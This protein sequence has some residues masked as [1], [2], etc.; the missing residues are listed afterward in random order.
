M[1][2]DK[3]KL[4]LFAITM[5]NIIAVDS[6]RTLPISAQYGFSLIFYYLIAGLFFF[7]PS[8][9]VSA[10]LGTGW[11][12]RGGIYIWIKEAFG[13]KTASIIIWIN[14]VYN[15]AWYPTIMALIAGVFAYTF[16][17]SLVDNPYYIISVILVLFW[18]ATFLNC[19]GM[20][21]S[22][23]IS[24]MGAIIGTLLPMLFIIVLAFVYL[25]QQRP[26]AIEISSH[27]FFPSGSTYDKLGFF[28]SILFGLLGLE[29]AATHAGEMVDPKRDYPKSLFI[30]VIAILSSIIL[31]S[32][33]IAIV[34][35]SGTLNLVVG[36]V[37]A[38]SAF[39]Q[40]F[41]MPYM[42][43][44]IAIAIVIGGLSGVSAWI[45]GPTKG[46]MVASRDEMLPKFFNKENEHG[47][48]I[49]T[50]LTQAVIV[51]LLSLFYLFMPSVNST[52]I[53]L[54]IVTA[55]LAMIV[56]I[57]LFAASII[58]HHKKRD[59]K[60]TFKIPG[61]NIG[62]W[63][64]AGSGITISVLALI[65]GFIPPKALLISNVASYELLLVGVMI[66]LSLLPLILSKL[67]TK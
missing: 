3:R 27:T 38:F 64:V 8:A 10:E 61:G 26:L 34:V 31:S 41:N 56:Y 51:T 35:P 52:F 5:I 43:K 65:A 15:L 36:T 22:A 62:I 23:W 9:L 40:T 60:R 13:K 49:N 25:Y 19:Y 4:S 1:V 44:V 45:I 47:A 37:Q 55:Q 54:S 30:A 7:I 57:T 39:F 63:L 58:L 67:S 48:P 50:L 32:L 21:L 2:R 28:S 29:M 33:A 53:F 18:L 14:W 66:I 17:P 11:P 59:V 20:R 42:T 46:I 16:N 12:E 24:G 6:I